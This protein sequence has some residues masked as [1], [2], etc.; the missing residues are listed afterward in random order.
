MHV[1]IMD[2]WRDTVDQHL[3]YIANLVEGFGTISGIY[4]YVWTL[5]HA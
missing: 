5:S 3:C 2:D 1:D 4:L